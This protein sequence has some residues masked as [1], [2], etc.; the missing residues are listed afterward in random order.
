MS[1]KA[2]YSPPR[3]CIF[4]F[5]NDG[6][7]HPD[8]SKLQLYIPQN[9][10]LPRCKILGYCLIVIRVQCQKLRRCLRLLSHVPTVCRA[11]A[12][13]GIRLSLTSFFHRVQIRRIDRRIGDSIYF[14]N[15]HLLKGVKRRNF[16]FYDSLRML[17]R[18]WCFSSFQFFLALVVS[19]ALFFLLSG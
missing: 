8:D 3:D 9:Y 12:D 6:A 5:K 4:S 11:T 17:K 13:V 19:H 2:N 1:P 15:W 7:F 14:P 16:L 18:S 10:W